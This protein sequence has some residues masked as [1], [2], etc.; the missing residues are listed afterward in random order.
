MKVNKLKL[1]EALFDDD[2]SIEADDTMS[3]FDWGEFDDD[4][5]MEDTDIPTG[6]KT[7]V[8]SG[9]ADTLMALINDEWEAIRGYNN[10]VEQLKVT[11]DA[12][13]DPSYS[14]MFA[15]IDDIRNEENKHVGQLQELLKLI[16][17]NA[18]SIE[19]G[20]VEGKSQMFNFVDGKLQ[21]QEAVQPV[22]HNP[23]S[24]TQ[25]NNA[26]HPTVTPQPQYHIISEE[27]GDITAQA[28]TGRENQISEVC[29]LSDVDDEM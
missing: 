27:R 17:P 1:D 14:Q 16:S 24:Q 3:N 19:Q 4:F 28:Q 9:V 20:A 23:Q 15:V 8:Q 11:F 7:G 26:F 12:T 6:P 13:Q 2:M 5:S 21:I 25:L 29:A 18:N 22:F 10:F